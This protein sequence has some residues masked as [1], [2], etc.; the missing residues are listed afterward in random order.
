MRERIGRY[1]LTGKLGEGGM[2][3]VYA[4]ED[5]RLGRVVALKM[6]RAETGDPAARDRLWREARSAA[7]VSH[8]NVCQLYEV[9]EEDGELFIAME[10]LEGESL[11][12]RLRRGPLPVV[13]ALETAIAMMGALAALHRRGL[14]HR[15]LK[16]SNVFLTPVGVKLLDFG[17]AR[18]ALG[19]VEQTEVGVTLAGNLVGTPQY[20]A[21][22]QFMAHPVDARTD[23]FAAGAVLFEALSGRPPFQGQSIVELYHA[24]T[25]EQPPVLGGSPVVAAADRIIH[26]ALAKRPEDRYPDA[27]AMT[28]ELRAA[29]RFTDRSEPVRAV[30]ITRLIVLPFRILRP[31]PETDFL[32]FSIPDDI[33][34]A[35]TGTPSLVVRS[36]VTA[37]RLAGGP[38]LDLRMIAAQADVDMVLTGTLLRAADQI[39]VNA[40]LVEVRDGTVRWSEIAQV[41]LGDLFQLQS[42]LVQRIVRSVPLTAGDRALQKRDV[43]A[44]AKAY[45]FYLRANQ[46]VAQASSWDIARDLYRQCLA[47]DPQYAPAWARLGRVY[48]LLALYGGAGSEEN[49]ARARESLARALELNPELS[50][51]HNVYTNLEVETGGAPAAMRRLLGRIRE[52]TDDP[53]LF[54]GL[55]QA[56]R[57]CD[58]LEPSAAAYARAIR[59]D[60][61][62]R[63]SAAHTYFAM[64]DYARAIET[65]VD[66]PPWIRFWALEAAGRRDEALALLRA[67]EASEPP[68]AVERFVVAMRTLLEGP[69]AEAIKYSE[70][71]LR[72]W[73]DHD[74]CGVYYIARGLAL[75][76]AHDSAMRG[77]GRAVERG[78]FCATLLKGD[79]WLEALRGRPDFKA[80]VGLAE[81]RVRAAQEA[82]RS[83]GGDRILGIAGER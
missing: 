77:I 68:R 9:G 75:L 74:P 52:R 64:G 42:D 2:G 8:P 63:T 6:I 32:A 57:Y 72:S 22:E 78:F 27:E 38:S 79:P 7:A 80:V 70:E 36:S 28:D 19:S 16:P 3:V 71:F 73:F 61:T 59:L 1:R 48:R 43:P 60:P 10:L 33:T 41:P 44:T 53:D 23:V 15:D 24:V 25:M 45:E 14:V 83:E 31:D 58:L 62:I 12:E 40:Q 20:M 46:L 69:R 47:E 65:C 34:A 18:F 66:E 50:V 49:R 37:S 11:A 30:A 54:A 4:A 17:L 81:T 39:R 35:L 29:L 5:E 76:G 67:V 55:V 13:E 26:R 82:F 51:A 56:C 21:P